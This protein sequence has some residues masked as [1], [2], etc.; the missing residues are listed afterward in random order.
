MKFKT[1]LDVP[2]TWYGG[3]PYFVARYA[4]QVISKN[5][6]N[7]KK[8]ARQVCTEDPPYM[9]LDIEMPGGGISHVAAVSD[10]AVLQLAQ[11][12]CSDSRVDE[13]RKE[14]DYI[15]AQKFDG[16]P[17]ADRRQ[18]DGRP[19]AKPENIDGKIATPQTS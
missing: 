13:I 7:V 8:I 16:R 14:L 12:F 6:F 4:R 1:L 19:T 10:T 17:T 2:R 15:R 18:T 9:N 5:R 11:H 3:R